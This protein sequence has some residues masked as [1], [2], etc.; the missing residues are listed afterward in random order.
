MAKDPRVQDVNGLAEAAKE[1]EK[2]AEKES[3]KK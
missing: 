3:K 1:S 2:A